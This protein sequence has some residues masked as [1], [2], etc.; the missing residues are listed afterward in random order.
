MRKPTKAV[1]SV[2]GTSRNLDSPV[3]IEIELFN[4]L[5]VPVLTYGCELLGDNIKR[6]IELVRMKFMKHGL[7][8]H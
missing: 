6:G 1:Y 7:Y 2:I 8:V 3:D 5:I 4:A